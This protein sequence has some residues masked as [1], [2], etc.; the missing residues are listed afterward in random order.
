MVLKL[1]AVSF[2]PLAGAIKEG[3]AAASIH[4]AHPSVAVKDFVGG[5]KEILARYPG[6]NPVHLSLELNGFLCTVRLGPAYQVSTGP[7]FWKEI[8]TWKAGVC[9]GGSTS[10]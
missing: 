8:E 2:K 6:E 10:G 9:G 3:I 7:V 5:L 1:R 4:V